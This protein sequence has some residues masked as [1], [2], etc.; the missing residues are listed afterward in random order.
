MPSYNPSLV[1]GPWAYPSYPPYVLPA[2][3][4]LLPRRRARGGPRLRRRHGDRRFAVGRLQ[5]GPSDIDIDVDRYNNIN[6]NR[7]INRN[8]NNWRH[9]S[10]NRDGVPYRDRASR[11]QYGRQLDGAGQRDSF[12]GHDPA[13][14]AERERASQSMSQRGFETPATS[15]REA[16][17]RAGQAS[18]Q[19]GRQQ[20]GAR[21]SQRAV[22]RGAQ[23]NAQA[24]EAHVSS[25]GQPQRQ[26]N[27]AFAGA[28]NPWQSRAC[29][30]RGPAAIP[31]AAVGGSRRRRAPD[32]PP[33]ASGVAAGVV[34]RRLRP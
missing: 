8:Q 19:M 26:S 9:N 2:V 16:R 4:G 33:G 3:A 31:V 18:Q 17:A 7:Q 21:R 12:R 1:Y 13:R 24:R 22:E 25:T 23:R 14:A 32:V 34:E 20:A 30:S 27:N 11:E 28:S 29:R 5:L 6:S 10:A 15:N